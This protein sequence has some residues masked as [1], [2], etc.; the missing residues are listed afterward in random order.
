MSWWDDS[1]VRMKEPNTILD[2]LNPV[3]D[4]HWKVEL[5]ETEALKKS[6]IHLK[7]QDT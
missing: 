3:N 4:F 7:R 6:L 5:H 1:M 2:L